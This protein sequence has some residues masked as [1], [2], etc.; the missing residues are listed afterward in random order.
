MVRPSWE[1]YRSGAQPELPGDSR[2]QLVVLWASLSDGKGPQLR[3][4]QP[5]RFGQS[6]WL[7]TGTGSCCGS[8]GPCRDPEG[9]R[10]VPAMTSQRI[11]VGVA[12]VQLAAQL[13]GMSVAVRRGLPYDVRVV[14]MRGEADDIGRDLWDK[15]TA[16][17]APVTML[18]TQAVAIAL[19]ATN[20]NA[21]VGRVAAKVLGGLGALNIGGYLGER[22]VRERLR[23][24]GW[25]HVETPVA[26]VSL[27]LATAM[28]ALGLGRSRV[29]DPN[30]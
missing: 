5:D 24:S 22:V 12:T 15:G 14:G 11:L 3:W 23:P 26:V 10:R 25:D 4:I 7:L 2:V 1:L 13:I 20:P 16:L 18:G 29:A 30:P 17:S 21:S 8:P 6:M 9:R 27:A 19:V 28:A